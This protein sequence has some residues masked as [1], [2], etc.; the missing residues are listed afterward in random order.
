MDL[1]IDT[2]KANE[3]YEELKRKKEEKGEEFCNA[4]PTPPRK[5]SME[6][7]DIPAVSDSTETPT[8]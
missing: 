7:L 1:S 5:G 4:P 2:D 3:E 6:L 8:P